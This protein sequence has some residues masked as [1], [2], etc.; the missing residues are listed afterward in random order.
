MVQ[1]M[2]RNYLQ[3]RVQKVKPG[4]RIIGI[5]G[6]GRGTGV[7]HF[8]ILLANYL[9]GVKR[10]KTAVLEWNSHHDFEKIRSVC[11][12]GKKQRFRVLEADYYADADGET[13]LE[14]MKRDYQHIIIDFGE[15]TEENRV[16]FFRCDRTWTL[17]SLSEWQM[18]ACW[19]F[20]AETGDVEKERWK[21]FVTFGSEEAR[22]EWKR[23]R[24]L[25][26]IRI[27][28]SVDAFTITGELMSWFARL[29]GEP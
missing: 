22:R 23:R 7:T 10:K 18:D 28:L 15:M 19:E 20:C 14:C 11:Q 4:D 12:A 25:S 2:F 3:K 5:I 9:S 29:M 26:F 6:Q 1:E 13:L 17:V 21:I 16:E 24:N 8:C 27:P